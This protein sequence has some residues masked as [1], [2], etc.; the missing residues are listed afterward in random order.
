[1]GEERK[2]EGVRGLLQAEE[3]VPRRRSAEERAETP[4]KPRSSQG[5]VVGDATAGGRRFGVDYRVDCPP[6]RTRVSRGVG[7]G[8]AE[9][10]GDHVPHQQAVGAD[11]SGGARGAVEVGPGGGLDGGGV[12]SG[13]VD[14]AGTREGAEKK[15][16]EAE[17]EKEKEKEKGK[18][19]ES[20]EAEK[21][22]SEKKE[23][24]KPKPK[25]KPSAKEKEV[26][27]DEELE[28]IEDADGDGDVE[29][30]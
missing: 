29:M 19:K 7:G 9:S 1:M 22:K 27:D 23:R 12:G 25:A 14:W 8:G 24:P 2:T 20:E 11:D 15:R 13:V 16:D 21:E 6:L 4:A 5:K 3:E 26:A 17:K 10:G 30:E 18:E 28:E